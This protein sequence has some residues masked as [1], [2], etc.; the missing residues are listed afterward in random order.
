MG[1]QLDTNFTRGAPTKFGRAKK[2]KIR[3]DFGQL[4]TLIANVSIRRKK[5]GELWSLTKKL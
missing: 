2:S 1:D 5:F 4:S 3:H